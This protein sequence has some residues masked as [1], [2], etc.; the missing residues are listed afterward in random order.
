MLADVRTVAMNI[1]MRS[2][3]VIATTNVLITTIAVKIIRKAAQNLHAPINVSHQS[4]LKAQL[5]LDATVMTNALNTETVAM[6]T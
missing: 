6:I 4:E 1:T 3:H 2:C 5:E